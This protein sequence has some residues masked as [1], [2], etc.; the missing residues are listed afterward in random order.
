M[1][2]PIPIDPDWAAVQ[3]RLLAQ[4]RGL[5]DGW[6]RGVSF[7][8]TSCLSPV[9]MGECP[10]PDPGTPGEPGVDE[11]QSFTIVAGGDG[12]PATGG[13]FTLT[14][15]E[16]TTAP[17]SFDATD[18]AIQTAVDAVLGAGN[19]L[20]SGGSIAYTGTLGEQNRAQLTGDGSALTGTGAPYTVS[21]STTTEGVPPVA[22]VPPETFKP[23]SRPES[24]TF[25]PVSLIQS[26]ACTA[27]GSID[28]EA[29][30]AV[31]LDRTRDFALSRELLTGAASDRDAAEPE[32]AN[33]SL[34]GQAFD[35]G[36]DF[37]SITD[38]L[39]CLEQTMG[40]A[41]S[42]RGSTLLVSLA[43][44]THL[45]DAGLVWRDGTR[46]FTA[47][48]SLVVASAGFDG[49]APGT[50]VSP[51]AGDPLY[52]YSVTALWAAVGSRAT[53]SDV[54][55]LV[56]TTTSRSEDL[57]LVAFPTCAVYAAASADVVAC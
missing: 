24:D 33:P 19:S 50:V 38:S 10:T 48:G 32:N 23:A 8:D 55:R 27:R 52:M 28:I 25:R 53:F 46:W 4:A 37:G 36:A 34:A 20:V 44:M 21:A 9:V 17:I 45:K 22:P 26:I 11:V 56:N 51:V 57:A 41:S 39:A 2:T 1:P 7:N 18:A 16:G 42:G 15:P 30:S 43:S 54:D 5:P 49:R 35:L 29:M 12:T 40:E 14:F 47:A 3:G 6:Q 13:T 31:E